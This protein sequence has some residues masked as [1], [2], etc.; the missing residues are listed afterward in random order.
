MAG[1]GRV[2]IFRYLVRNLCTLDSP[3]TYFETEN[4]LFLFQMTIDNLQIQLEQ[5]ESQIEQLSSKKKK[6]KDV[7]LGKNQIN[8]IHYLN[9]RNIC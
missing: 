4:N 3:T 2:L 7:R 6:D 5:F 8:F 9:L 1:M